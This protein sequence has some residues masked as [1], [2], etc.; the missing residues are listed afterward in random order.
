MT[1]VRITVALSVLVVGTWAACSSENPHSTG[2]VGGSDTVHPASM[3][4]PTA[5][6]ADM[7]FEA[8]YPVDM[9][10]LLGELAEDFQSLDSIT[11]SAHAI[12][13]IQ[14]ESISYQSFDEFPY[15][16]AT[17]IVGETWKGTFQPGDRITVVEV[18]GVFAGR[19]KVEPGARG[20]P[21]EV[22]V[23]GVPVM[24]PGERYLLFL[25]GPAHVGPV[26]SS[27]YSVKGVVQGKIRIG[28]DGRLQFTGRAESLDE[29]IF[30]VPRALVGRPYSDVRAEVEAIIRR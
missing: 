29:P 8:P 20:E 5:P 12:V 4:E 7:A 14:V 6:P 1:P 15:T 30:A 10:S 24:K 9:V 25:H 26:P 21:R 18:G 19:S 22:G 11:R 17:A 23:E 13:S 27:A 16:V 3:T 28:K 2:F